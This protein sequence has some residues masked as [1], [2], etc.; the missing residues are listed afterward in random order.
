MTVILSVSKAVYDFL[1]YRLSAEITHF[2]KEL[3]SVFPL[4]SYDISRELRFI[5][6]TINV[7]R[8]GSATIYRDEYLRNIYPLSILT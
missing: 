3:N 8:D 6:C 1:V 4:C 5:G 2:F 7:S